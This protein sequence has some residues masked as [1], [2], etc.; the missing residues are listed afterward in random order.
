MK[1]SITLKQMANMTGFSVSTISKAWNDKYDISANT[2]K[3]I[4]EV[5]KHHNYTP[6]HLA[7]SLRKQK[8]ETI[9]LVVPDISNFQYARIVSE[10]QRITFKRGLKLLVFQHFED[11]NLE[12]KCINS[13]NHSFVDGAIVI[14][15]KLTKIA[16]A[17]SI[18]KPNIVIELKNINMLNLNHENLVNIYF[19]KLIK[20]IH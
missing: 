2:K 9:A 7:I 11:K 13:L 14:A 4:L 17:K 15:S 3:K 8:T 19:E 10:M 1:E 20:I 6:N 12:N 18:L 16:C 5:A